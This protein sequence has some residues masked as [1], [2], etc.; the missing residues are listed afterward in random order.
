MPIV[1]PKEI[2]GFRYAKAVPFD[3]SS[4]ALETLLPPTFRLAVLDGRESSR[5]DEENQ[6]I[7]R[8]VEALSSHKRLQGFSEPSGKRLLDKVVRSSLIRTVRR[9][10]TRETVIDGLIPY[11]LASFKAGFP[12]NQSGFRQVDRFLYQL[13][14]SQWGDDPERVRKFLVLVFGTGL[15][16]EGYPDPSV[17]RR[18][19][20][21][22]QLDA[23][24]ELS[25]AYI[26]GFKA[27]N[28]R[29]SIRAHV[30][31]EPLPTFQQAFGKDLYRYMWSYN[32]RVPTTVLVD[33]LIALIAF[34]LLVLSLKL[35]LR[36]SR[37]CY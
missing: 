25:I 1:L 4:V 2:R 3:L 17:E 36:H 19:G 9:A 29:R 6:D 16:I 14:L 22:P 26:D 35:L 37:T 5:V 21:H 24:T 12:S 28:P 13:M 18:P 7:D 32:D 15:F 8:S 31:P 10:R 11:S 23:I 30:V 20:V 33:Q 27:S 34:E